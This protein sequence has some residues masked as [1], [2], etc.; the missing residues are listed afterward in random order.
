MFA[1]QFNLR[2]AWGL[3]QYRNEARACLFVNSGAIASH[4]MDLRTPA[5]RG[6]LVQLL[7]DWSLCEL[8]QLGVDPTIRY[9]SDLRCWQI[10]VHDTTDPTPADEVGIDVDDGGRAFRTVPHYVNQIYV[11]ADRLFGRHTRCFPAT[12]TEPVSADAPLMEDVLLKD[13]WTYVESEG[14]IVGELGEVEFHRRIRPTAQDDDARR[15]LPTMTCGGA[16]RISRGGAYTVET[17]DTVLGE[18][19]RDVLRTGPDGFRFHY[20]HMRM[21]SFPIAKRLRSITSVYEMIVVAADVLDAVWFLYDRHQIL[22]RDLSD[23]NVM[24]QDREGGRNCGL[25]IDLDNAILNTA[26]T[27]DT[28]RIRTGTPPFLSVANIEQMGV[29]PALVD[30]L[31]ALLY[32]LIWLGVWGCTCMNRGRVLFEDFRAVLREYADI[33]QTRLDNPGAAQGMDTASA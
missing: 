2:F 13:S 29:R 23:N 26:E 11:A 22:H 24:V 6:E 5:G 31:E 21:A 32:L 9:R 18:A 1:S 20:A 7:V 19:L 30:E 25:L 17:T 10:D 14:R 15:F 4:A 16:V 3:T 27:I 8:H 33:A 28:R 12:A